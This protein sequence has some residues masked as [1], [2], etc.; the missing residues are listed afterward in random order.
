MQQKVQ[1]ASHEIENLAFGPFVCHV[2]DDSA[3][4]NRSNQIDRRRLTAIDRKIDRRSNQGEVPD[5]VEKSYGENQ[6]FIKQK[7]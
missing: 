4:V 7:R 1:S 2:A 3:V 6:I 5:L